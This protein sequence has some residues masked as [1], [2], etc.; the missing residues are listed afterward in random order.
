[1]VDSAIAFHRSCTVSHIIQVLKKTLLNISHKLPWSLAN[2]RSL[3]EW[4]ITFGLPYIPGDC[5]STCRKCGDLGLESRNIKI[6]SPF[7]I[8]RAYILSSNR[9]AP[10]IILHR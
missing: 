3:S 1:P 2:C 9:N 4:L 6:G 5:S 7:E 10:S 8:T